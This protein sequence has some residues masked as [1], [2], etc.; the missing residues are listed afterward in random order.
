MLV[1][2]PL[3][4]LV[5]LALIQGITE[6]LPISSSAHLILAPVLVDGWND[7][8]PV[9][10]VA[11]HVGSLFAVLI[12]FRAETIRLTRGA[13]DT[14]FARPGAD[15]QLFL[16]L[17]AASLPLLIAGAAIALTGV[18]DHLRSPL[19]IGVASIVFGIALGL[20]DRADTE[21]A[22]RVE[23]LSFGH[24][25][26]VGLAQVLALIPGASRSGV[27]MT[28]ARALGWSRTEAARFSMLLAIPSIAAIGLFAGLDLVTGTISQA[29]PTA[30]LI[31]AA[32]SFVAAISA[33]HIFLKLTRSVSFLPFVIYRVAMGLG[34]IAFAFMAGTG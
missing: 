19:V 22:H 23:T 25:M 21:P 31:V 15:R 26:K 28:A 3:V 1:A 14:L 24:A 12:Y 6:F 29:S 18:I 5:V 7:Q 30:A 34:L 4:Q 32:L 27:T 13:F 16:F 33:I 8:G 17:L 2:L 20:S 9:I 10:D 11:A